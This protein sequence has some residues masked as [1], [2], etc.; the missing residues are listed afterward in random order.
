MPAQTFLTQ[1][2]N[3]WRLASAPPPRG[4]YIRLLTVQGVN[5][6]HPIRQ[7][8]HVELHRV[9]TVLR[10]S[11]HLRRDGAEQVFRLRFMKLRFFFIRLIQ[12]R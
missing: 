6:S 3:K 2:P 5:L 9:L 1:T 10:C 4:L 7:T 11:L 8:V 12:R